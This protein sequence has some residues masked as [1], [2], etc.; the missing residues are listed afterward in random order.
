VKLFGHNGALEWKQE[1]R[2]LVVTC[3]AEMP[4]AIAGTFCIE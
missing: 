4:L 1:P 3:P 2:D